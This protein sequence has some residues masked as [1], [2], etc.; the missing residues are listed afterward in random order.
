MKIL[1][2]ST[3]F[4]R[5]PR[6]SFAPFILKHC[7]NLHDAGWEVYVLVP[8]YAGLPLKEDWDGIRIM[9]F[10]YF[11][12]RF[13]DWPYKGGIL[14]QIKRKPWTAI[15]L[16]F[17]IVSMYSNTLKIIRTEN[18]DMVNF[19]WLFP[20][21]LWLKRIAR[22]I[23]IPIVLTGHG[24]DIWLAAGKFMKRM[25][26][27]GAFKAASA[28]TVNSEFMLGVLS[29]CNLPGI[30][31]VIPMAVDIEKFKPL[32]S[33]PSRSNLVIAVGRVLKSKGLFEL[34]DA[35]AEV[36]TRVPDARLEIIGEGPAKIPLKKKIEEKK[37]GDF[38]ALLEPINNN[39]LPEKYRSA[40]V[41]A[42]P[43]LVPEGLGMTAVEAAA[44]GVPSITYGLG[45]TSE[46]VAHDHNGIIVGHS[47]EALVE[48]LLRLYSDDD[49]T[50]YLGENAR[51]TVE[52]S[53]SWDVVAKKF[54]DLFLGLLRS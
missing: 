9:R 33:K 46:F 23:N 34:V 42:L 21:S 14:P 4:P 49:L 54:N 35:M 3:S 32:D 45:G 16:L 20:C 39:E 48:G 17:Y 26:T 27:N 47:H 31:K 29:K 12:E 8:H 5:W 28:L 41:L 51:A 18:I 30:V 2:V 13:Q 44:C 7:R 1:V 53:F 22:K 24:T 6:D 11:I 40:R 19:H 52:K 10:R 38:I 25:F 50:D 37:L 43:S 36:K 15:K